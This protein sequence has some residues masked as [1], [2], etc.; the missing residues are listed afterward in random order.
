MSSEDLLTWLPR[1]QKELRAES[2]GLRK[3]CRFY[4]LSKAEHVVGLQEGEP[5][6]VDYDATYTPED[7]V[8]E[9]AYDDELWPLL[10]THAYRE[11]H[12]LCLLYEMRREYI[13]GSIELPDMPDPSERIPSH[14]EFK[15]TERVSIKVNDAEAFTKWV[16][17][18]RDIELM[19]G[20]S[21]ETLMENMVFLVKKHAED[22]VRRRYS[23][24]RGVSVE[25]QVCWHS[26][27][28]ENVIRLLA[29]LD[30]EKSTLVLKEDI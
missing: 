22:E 17:A 16:H 26:P 1:F 28:A 8:K 21:V 15:A 6:M 19:H 18:F 25:E 29:C 9:L 7:Y 14:Q 24:T 10:Y 5:I 20:Q 2:N 12:G 30:L 4:T 11:Q 23:N 27:D 13:K 3:W